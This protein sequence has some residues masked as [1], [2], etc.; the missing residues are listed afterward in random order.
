MFW[1]YFKPKESFQRHEA[2][3]SFG[4]YSSNIKDNVRPLIKIDAAALLCVE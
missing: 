1:V 2:A 3:Y 4:K